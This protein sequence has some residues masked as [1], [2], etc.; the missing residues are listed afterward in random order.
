MSY[1]DIAE[2]LQEI[3]QEMMDNEEYPESKELDFN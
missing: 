2:E 3:A 1:E